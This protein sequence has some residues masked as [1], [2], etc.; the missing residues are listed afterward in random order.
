MGLRYPSEE[1]E[2]QEDYAIQLRERLEYAYKLA[3]QAQGKASKHQKGHYDLKVRGA[4]P[5]VGARVLVKRVGLKGKHKL[6]DRWGC[7]NHR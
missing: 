3:S 1:S 2:L 6:A 5:Q 7:L 4:V